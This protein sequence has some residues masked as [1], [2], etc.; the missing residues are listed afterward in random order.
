M[1]W[2]HAIIAFAGAT[3]LLSG[4]VGVT[5]ATID[6]FTDKGTKLE[7]ATASTVTEAGTVATDVEKTTPKISLSKWSGQAQMGITYM[8]M[9]STTP[10]ARS[11]MSKNVEWVDANQTMQ[12]VPLDASITMED[13]GMEINIILNS[14]PATTTFNFKIDGAD[15]LDFFYQAPLWQDAGLKAPTADCTD[16]DCNPDGTGM[17]HR[18]ANTVGSYA[19]FYKNHLNHL[20]GQMNY[21]TGKAYHI[22]RPQV[23]DAKGHTIWADLSYANGV[24]TVTV[25]QTFLDTATYPVK[26]DPT[27]GYTTQGTAATDAFT[28][29]SVAQASMVSIV[30]AT[31]GDTITKY[32]IYAAG[33]GGDTNLAITS[34]TVAGGLPST[35]LAAKTD[36]LALASGF[37]WYNSGAVSQAMAQDTLYTVAFSG[38]DAA[39]TTVSLTYDNGSTPGRFAST[40]TTL[41]AS[42]SPTGSDDGRHY[43]AYATYTEP[44]RIVNTSAFTYCRTITSNND[45]Y[46]DGIGTT[47][48]GLFPLVAT[49]TISTLAATSSGGNVQ[50][51]TNNKQT[52][53]DVVF[54]DESTCSFGASSTAIPHFF[55]KYASTT[56]AFTVHL[57]TSNISST[58][59]KVLAMYYGNSAFS[60]NLNSPG[61]TYATT[62]PLGP[63]GIWTLGLPGVA[64]TT[65]PDFLD[66]TY[67]GNN[68]FSVVM[69]NANIVTG[70]VDGALNFD[71][72][73]QY[74]TTPDGTSLDPTVITVCAWINPVTNSQ[75]FPVIVNKETGSSG[76]IMHIISTTEIKWKVNG[77][78]PNS[79]T[80]SGLGL[81]MAAWSHV[82]GTYDGANLKIYVNAVLKGTK[83]R[84]GT[85]TDSTQQLSFG[86]YQTGTADTF[87][88]GS[89]DDVRIYARALTSSDIQTIYNNEVN[90]TVFWTFGNQQTL[91][92]AVS[93]GMPAVLIKSAFRILRQLRIH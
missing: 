38:E 92:A 8:G 82:C 6:P 81:P 62:S 25:P 37:A 89:E 21:A 80:T 31:A 79:V 10:G 18:P 93:G 42:F 55:E 40:L 36:I 76:Y 63:A 88:K 9:A 16:T 65:F 52:P 5:D 4:G 29:A 11:F 67:N 84:A 64:T 70:Q 73:T 1:V 17:S 12:V 86:T 90:S 78:D 57:G 20:E 48:T 69:A 39:A 91:A 22:Y 26:V 41:G 34:Y 32:S 33:S 75:S 47:T 72:T 74:V 14:N 28:T 7:I 35:R 50:Q 44:S 46:T 66:A 23:T 56:G 54:V 19:V 27:F 43:S 3:S 49:S 24:L 2:K 13:G 51:T 53:L 60:T 30:H 59:A 68:G 83:A 87:F 58:S 45:G 77:D 85:I 15:G 71:G 61:Q